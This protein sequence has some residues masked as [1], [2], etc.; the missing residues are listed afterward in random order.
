LATNATK[1]G[2]LS[3]PKGRVVIEWALA[4]SEGKRCLRLEWRETGGPTVQP[5]THSGFGM[6]VIKGFLM[7][8]LGASVALTLD[9]EGARC[10]IELPAR[11][12]VDDGMTEGSEARSKRDVLPA[13]QR[14]ILVVEDSSVI[15]LE[16]AATLRQKGFEM[17]GPA[18]TVTSAMML[19]DQ[20]SV[21]AAVLD[22]N[23]DGEN[24]QPIAE[25]LQSQSIPYV[26]ATGYDPLTV[27]PSHLSN[28]PC[29]RKPFRRREL[30]D[31]LAELLRA[32]S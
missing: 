17:I 10:V 23:L 4:T 8:D 15:C 27:L 19:L 21:D 9:P 11:Q 16:I 25:R 26:L 20:Q 31:A 2:A 13:T 22:L 5:P 32:D 18:A 3:A 1:Y 24:A 28:T 30:A 7:A 12:L 29:V 14:R 6:T